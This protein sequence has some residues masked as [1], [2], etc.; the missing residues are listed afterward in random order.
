MMSKDTPEVGDV[1]IHKKQGRP[2]YITDVGGNYISFLSYTI[3]ELT[4]RKWKN[5]Y[6]NT[7]CGL[8]DDERYTRFTE[9]YKYLGKSKANINDLFKTENEE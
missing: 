5:F 9:I 2:M 1:W 6:T 4:L 7:F 8:H 3:D